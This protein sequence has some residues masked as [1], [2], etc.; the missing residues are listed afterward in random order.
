[1]NIIIY[2]RKKKSTNGRL[3]KKKKAVATVTIVPLGNV[4]TKKKKD[5]VAQ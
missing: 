5:E 3:N 2:K 4:A 1:M